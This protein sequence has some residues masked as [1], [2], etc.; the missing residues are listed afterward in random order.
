VQMWAEPVMI[1]KARLALP[2]TAIARM[3]GAE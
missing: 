3:S 2:A 1:V